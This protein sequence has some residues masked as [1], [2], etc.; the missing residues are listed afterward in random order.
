MVMKLLGLERSICDIVKT[1]LDF[2]TQMSRRACCTVLVFQLPGHCI[3]AVVYHVVLNE[4]CIR[5]SVGSLRM[6]FL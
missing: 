5:A 3:V 1:L 6:S 2:R 4:I